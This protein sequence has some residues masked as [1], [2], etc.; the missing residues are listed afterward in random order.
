MELVARG[1][2]L[3]LPNLILAGDLNLTLNGYEIWGTKEIPDPLGPFF[4]KIFSDHQLADVA[5]TC[6][7]PT[8]RN[9]RL[10]DEG[11]CKRFDRFLLSFHL[12]SLLTR[13]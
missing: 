1:G 13:H 4:T 2:L 9:G 5:P 3:T 12:V 7:G 8:R 11:I 10:G 6:A